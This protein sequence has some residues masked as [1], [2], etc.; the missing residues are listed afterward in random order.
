MQVLLVA[1]AVF[2]VTT[3]S[4]L[5]ATTPHYSAPP[6][7]DDEVEMD[8]KDY[9][10]GYAGNVCAPACGYDG[11]CITD[12]PPSSA[13]ATCLLHDASG[14]KYCALACFLGC[15]HSG[16][17]CLR[18]GPPS[19]R[20]VCAWRDSTANTTVETIEVRKTTTGGSPWS[21][22]ATSAKEGLWI[23]FVHK[24]DRM[25]TTKEEEALR[26]QIFNGNL[27]RVK[28]LQEESN[29][30]EYSHLSP[31]ADWDA[32]EFRAINTLRQNRPWPHTPCHSWIL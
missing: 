17:E 28:R 15:G 19:N 14:K 13:T 18:L 32:D 24:F 10:T 29:G 23:E 8:I 27:D 9:E 12:K 5:P 6:C 20:R 11:S 16:L 21:V 7:L 2:F 4:A 25:F 30:V 26:H 1:L 22:S 3:T 31:F